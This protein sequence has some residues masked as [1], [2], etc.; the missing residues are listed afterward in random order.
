MPSSGEITLWRAQL[1]EAEAALHSIVVNGSVARMRHGDKSMEFNAQNV[2]TLRAY[3]AELRGRLG[4]PG[5]GSACELLMT[6]LLGP[7]GS[8]VKLPALRS[9]SRILAAGYAGA[10]V[11]DPDLTQW[12]PPLWSAQT[13]L[14]PDRP[15]LA[16]RIHDLARNDGWASGGVTRQV[17]AVIGAGWRLSSKPNARSLRVDPD[18]A[19]DVASDELAAVLSNRNIAPKQR[20]E[21]LKFLVHF[22]ADIHQPL[23]CANDNDRGGNGIRVEFNGEPTNLHAVWDTGILTR[24]VNGNE[25][26]YAVA[27]ARSTKQSALWRGSSIDWANESYAIASAAIYRDLPEANGILPMSYEAD[28]LPIVDEQLCRAALRLAALLNTVLSEQQ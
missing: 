14:S 3:I 13:A 12:R 6:S 28:M 15:V 9:A 26:A 10:S 27:L 17:D 24:A 25:R 22:V 8:P 21:A 20:L 4:L 1:V 19:S 7:D 2:G 23:H 16:A 18:V 5:R 11:T